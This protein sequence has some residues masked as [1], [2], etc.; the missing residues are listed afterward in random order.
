[1]EFFCLRPE[2]IISI[3]ETQLL[4]V[5]SVT[6]LIDASD[7]PRRPELLPEDHWLRQG[8]HSA[9]PVPSLT[10]QREPVAAVSPDS[11]LSTALSGKAVEPLEPDLRQPH[12]FL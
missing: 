7:E 1:L 3:R 10:R 11:W 2:F 9:T 6:A 8:L 12:E 4:S 5:Y